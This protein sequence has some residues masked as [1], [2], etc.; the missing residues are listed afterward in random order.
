MKA[1][2]SLQ[3]T[4]LA[5]SCLLVNAGRPPTA[6]LDE[7]AAMSARMTSFSD[8]ALSRDGKWVA[9]VQSGQGRQGGLFAAELGTSVTNAFRVTAGSSPDW[10]PGSG[11]LALLREE[12]GQGQKQ[13]WITAAKGRAPK[14]LTKVQGFVA[15]PRWSPDGKRIAF[16]LVEGGQGGGPLNAQQRASGRRV[17]ASSSTLTNSVY[18]RAEPSSRQIRR[19]GRSE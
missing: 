7:L 18:D 13:V 6:D 3:A 9:W 14:A 19:K 16:L 5:F 2:R 8:V 11:R 12:G 10:S 4:L 15:C 17:T 1:L